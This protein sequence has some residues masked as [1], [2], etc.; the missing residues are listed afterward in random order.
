MR[1]TLALC[2][3]FAI[4]VIELSSRIVMDG[5]ITS[6]RRFCFVWSWYGLSLGWSLAIIVPAV[7]LL[8]RSSGKMT[9]K[10][11]FAVHILQQRSMEAIMIAPRSVPAFDLEVPSFIRGPRMSRR[12]LVWFVSESFRNLANSGALMTDLTTA[13]CS[14]TSFWRF[15]AEAAGSNY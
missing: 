14:A 5:V 11:N 7:N 12:C 9:W 4:M 8:P 1:R 6:L 13:D 15:S 2:K 10:L 3:L